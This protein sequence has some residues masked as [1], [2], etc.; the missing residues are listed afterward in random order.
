MPPVKVAVDVP[1]PPGIE[2][3][4]SDTVKTGVGGVG[5]IGV[6]ARLEIVVVAE[7]WF[8]GVIVIVVFPD[9]PNQKGTLLGL[10]VSVKSWIATG[11]V[12][13]SLNVVMGP[14]PTGTWI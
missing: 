7:K 14:V 11:I 12:M 2:V 6:G 4:D 9:W 8:T 5:A 13:A 10:A 3:G 1:E